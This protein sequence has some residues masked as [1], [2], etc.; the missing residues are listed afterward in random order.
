[1]NAYALGPMPELIPR[2]PTWITPERAT[3]IWRERKHMALFVTL[4][5]EEDAE[6]SRVWKTL[7][8]SYSWVAALLSIA[9]GRH[10][11]R[12]R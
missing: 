5:P 7:P 10:P 4:T 9:Q 12:P 1:M 3:A 2:E 8:G 11:V 6:V